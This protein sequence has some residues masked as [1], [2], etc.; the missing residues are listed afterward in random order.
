MV[1]QEIEQ[2]R[3]NWSDS[4]KLQCTRTLYTQ[5]S[6]V[7]STTSKIASDNGNAVPAGKKVVCR[8]YNSG[9]CAQDSDHTNGNTLYRHICYHCFRVFKKS[10]QHPE[11]KCSGK[12]NGKN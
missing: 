3:L 10:A 11:N 5:R 9:K 6:Q 7:S 4:E 2:G 12:K 1:L 8:F